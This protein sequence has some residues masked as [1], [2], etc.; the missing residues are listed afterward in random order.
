M[1]KRLMLIISLGLLSVL[2]MS[3]TGGKAISI[4]KNGYFYNLSEDKSVGK[5]ASDFFITPKYSSFVADDGNTYVNIE[6]EVDIRR[7]MKGMTSYLELSDMFDKSTIEEMIDLVMDEMDVTNMLYQFLVD[8]REGEFVL[9]AVETDG[10]A[11]DIS[12]ALTM[13]LL[14]P[15]DLGAILTDEFLDDLYY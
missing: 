11:E 8:T 9:N 10:E 12:L 2:L 3:C 14:D 13:L 5:A 15:E 1:K 6:G 4:V 7:I